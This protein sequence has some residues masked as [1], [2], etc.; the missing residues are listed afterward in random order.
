MVK[1]I[2]GTVNGVGGNFGNSRRGGVKTGGG[3]KSVGGSDKRFYGHAVGR[4]LARGSTATSR[5]IYIVM[6][7]SDIVDGALEA[8]FDDLTY[9]LYILLTG[10]YPE[11]DRRGCKHPQA[12][13]PTNSTDW[14]M[15]VVFQKGGW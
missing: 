13:Q 14:K 11:N 4:L 2:Y 3:V 8:F 15:A 5:F 10:R 6:K 7:E 12:G 1:G 9:S